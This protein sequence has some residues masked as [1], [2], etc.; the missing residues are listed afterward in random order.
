MK[1]KITIKCENNHTLTMASDVEDIVEASERAK[2]L[3][4]ELGYVVKSVDIKPFADALQERAR[5]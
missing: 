5:K 1:W 4:T 2:N 3:A